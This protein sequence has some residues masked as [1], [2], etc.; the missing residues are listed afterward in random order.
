MYGFHSD[1]DEY[2]SEEYLAK[3]YKY[4]IE[5][6]KGMPEMRG[7][8]PWLLFDF[9]YTNAYHPV[10]QQGWNRKGA[11]SEKGDKKLHWY[12]L[13]DFYDEMEERYR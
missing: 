5:L 2:F 9:V 6:M 12:L 7:S 10:Y 4:Q 1:D 13:K 3:I 8:I 11:Y